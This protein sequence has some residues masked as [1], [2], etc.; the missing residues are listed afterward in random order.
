MRAR[1]LGRL[2][3]CSA[4]AGIAFGGTAPHADAKRGY[5]VLPPGVSPGFVVRGSNDY[6][7]E[8]SGRGKQVALRV[9]RPGK[10]SAIYHIPRQA[11]GDAI[12]A[13]LGILGRI[14]LWFDVKSVKV[15]PG[16]PDCHGKPSLLERGT[17]RG[18]MRFRG[19]D[20]YTGISARHIKGYVF[21][22]FRQV[23]KL[24]VPHKSDRP[25]KE[26][27]DGVPR[28]LSALGAAMSSSHRSVSLGFISVVFPRR[29]GGRRFSL[30]IAEAEV[31]E[32]RGRITIKRS[33]LLL[34]D[35][36][37][38]IFG[39]AG[40]S[41]T[42]TLSLPPPFAGSGTYAIGPEGTPT[43]TG[44]LRVSLPG[45][46]PVALTGGSFVAALCQGTMLE[47]ISRCM[48]PVN[49][50]YKRGPRLR[51]PRRNTAQGSGSQSQAF[52]DARLS[53]SR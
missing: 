37:A 41:P 8:V 22:S 15:V 46:S 14:D 13:N 24:S 33:V 35:E 2:L 39:P 47:E 3:V 29:P 20:G 4:C 18:T 12:K 51:V 42:A 49:I 6:T 10:G 19:E 7:I 38:L 45:A 43:W 25:T 11:R 50:E 1:S 44:S 28:E 48:R 27:S 31:R 40:D 52:W 34:P 21:R 32:R 36:S 26:K 30:V 53:W 9:S 16:G 5:S 23:C 17:F